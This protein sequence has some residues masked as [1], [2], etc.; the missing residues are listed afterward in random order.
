MG[1]K[2]CKYA[3]ET[4]IK[5]PSHR[6]SDT[7]MNYQWQ[8]EILKILDTNSVSLYD[9]LLFI[10]RGRLEVHSHHRSILQ[11]RTSDIL[12]LWS[13]QLPSEA[14][15]WAVRAATE[16]YR[17]DVIKLIQPHSGFPRASLGNSN[18]VVAGEDSANDAN[19][20]ETW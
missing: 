6:N 3:R 11:H 18:H 15:E 14:R 13:E 4:T 17:D 7:I 19:L 1:Y 9:L 2:R 20:P 12:D 16:V 10:L 8:S 5:S